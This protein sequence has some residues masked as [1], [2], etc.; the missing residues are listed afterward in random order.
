[1]TPRPAIVRVITWLPVGGIERRLVATL[2]RLAALGWDVSLACLRERGALADQLEAAG[3]PV[4]V[5][6][7]RSR[8][9]PLA[10]RALAAHF[11]ARR[12]SIVH[13]HMYRSNIPATIAARAAGVPAMFAHIHN[14]GTW[15]TPRQAWLDRATARWRTGTIA[16]SEAVAADVR[17]TLRLPPERVPVIHNGIDTEEFRPDPALREATRAALGI[18]PGERMVLVPARLHPN[19]N[20]LGMI[21]A[22]AAAAPPE[23]R[24]AFAGDGPMRAEI[25]AALAARGLGSRAMLLGRRDDMPA[26]Y[27]AADLTALPSLKEGFSNAILEALACGCPV[28]ASDAGGNGEAIT[29]ETGWLHRAGDQEGLRRDL[30]AALAGDAA[31]RATACRTRA[32][33]FSI[34]RMIANVHALYCRAL[35]ISGP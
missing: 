15:E 22:F 5:I 10:L 17:A 8:L 16:V 32:L 30:A 6:P 33:E 13:A 7:F 4:R 2:P 24:L 21:E 19:K 3:V 20:P 26:L 11:R 27:N 28:L 12:A 23:A 34:D 29:P 1:V 14:V 35:G 31:G 25:E 9:S 18:A